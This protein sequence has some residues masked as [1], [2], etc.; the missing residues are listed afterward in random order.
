MAEFNIGK[1]IP[2]FKG[3]Y[4]TKEIYEEL[5]VV[6]HNACTWVSQSNNNQTEPSEDNTK[7]KLVMQSPISQADVNNLNNIFL[8]MITDRLDEISKKIQ[9]NTADIKE[10]HGL[11]LDSINTTAFVRTKLNEFGT[12]LSKIEKKLGI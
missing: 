4:T 5:D 6:A 7:W 2:Q 3:R 9:E 1:V 12:R 8:P 11:V 10:Q